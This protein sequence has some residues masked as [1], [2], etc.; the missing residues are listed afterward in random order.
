MNQIWLQIF[1][2]MIGGSIVKAIIFNSWVWVFVDIAVLVICYLILRRHSN[3][4][5]KSS[6]LFLSGLTFISILMD[7]SVVGGVAGNVLILVL[8]GWMVFKRGG[9]NNSNNGNSKRTI[10]RHKWHK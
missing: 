5:I 1:V 9:N 7:L 10:V 8:I 2:A 6:M 3:V 4:D